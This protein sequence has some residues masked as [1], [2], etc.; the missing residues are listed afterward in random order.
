M[1]DEK[2][3][4]EQFWTWFARHKV[5]FAKLANTDESS[6]DLALEQLKRVDEHFCFD[7][8]RDRHPAREF[9]VPAQGM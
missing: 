1:V 6:W 8:S 7:L 9:I 4:I 5:K 2:D 3:R